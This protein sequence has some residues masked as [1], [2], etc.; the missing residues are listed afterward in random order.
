MA[1]F[2]SSRTRPSRRGRRGNVALIGALG[3]VPIVLAVAYGVEL[4]GISGERA[5][6]QAAVDAAALAGAR[7]MSVLTRGD[8]GV[9][10]TATDYGQAKL[11]GFEHAAQV[12]F[13]TQINRQAGDLTVGA[14]YVRSRSASLF[15]SGGQVIQVSATAE[16]L[17]SMPLC[18]LQTKLAGQGG[19]VL[20]DQATLRAPGCLVHANT[21]ISLATGTSVQ[22][23]VVQSSGAVRGTTSTKVQTGAMQVTDPFEALDLTVPGGCPADPADI[24]VKG[25]EVL[26]LPA[27]VHCNDFRIKGSATLELLP[28]EHWFLG[29]LEFR[30]NTRLTGDDV[31]LIFGSDDEFD[32]GDRAEITLSARR[33]R[34]LAGFLIATTRNNTETFTIASDKVRELLGT[35]Y[36]PNA[37]LVI[38]T[39]GSVAE[40][41]A[42]SVIVAETLTLRRNPVLVINTSYVGSGVPV[43]DGVGPNAGA[44]RLS[45]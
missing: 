35:I 12:T 30:G 14:T 33:T 1:L 9:S 15:G 23:G 41:S 10:R 34:A 4:S 22:A 20:E 38:E 16:S 24:D 26:Q 29:E 5:L 17:N 7:E 40:D 42:W 8:D 21:S 13:T 28:G 36:I 3:A 11:A 25:N 31:V 43:P 45:R 37:K 44:P 6:L 18:V 39:T 32:F 27:G 19:M 2:H